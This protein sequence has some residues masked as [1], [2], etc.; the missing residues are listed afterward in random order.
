MAK[1]NLILLIVA[2]IMSLVIGLGI[3]WFFSIASQPADKNEVAQSGEAAAKAKYDEKK[4][5]TYAVSKE[6]ILTNLSMDESKRQGVIK[7]K[8]QLLVADDKILT[9]IQERSAEVVDIMISV[10]RSKTPEDMTKPDAKETIKAEMVKKM[11]EAFK[12][13][14]I[15]DAFFE[16]FII[17][18]S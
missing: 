11:N 1:S 2:V 3:G 5:Q 10:L 14:K 7:A 9:K 17:Q 12:T 6:A 8:A 15:L 4:F 18:N 13:D 16:E